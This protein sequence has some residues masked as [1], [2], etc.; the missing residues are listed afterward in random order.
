MHNHIKAGSIGLA[1]LLGCAAA[2]H[3]QQ[4][5]AL[6]DVARPT[7]VVPHTA[8]GETKV[9]QSPDG[10]FQLQYPTSWE[11]VSTSDLK[12][13]AHAVSG[14]VN[15]NANVTIEE[16]PPGT[17]LDAYVD[18]ALAVFANLIEVKPPVDRTTITLNGTPAVRLGIVARMPL[19][20]NV[21]VDLHFDTL[22][23]VVNGKGYVLTCT[24]SNEAAVVMRPVFDR[25]IA[26]LR[27]TK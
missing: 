21:R 15:A 12:F 22:V 23:A 27:F 19:S 25:I 20:M 24:T 13:H 8:P 7:Q 26:S 5:R 6:E 17:T 10:D 18:K 14:L 1:F 11:I 16:L 4:T 9:F 3:V 2:P